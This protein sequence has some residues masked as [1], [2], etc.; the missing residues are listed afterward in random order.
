[1]DR[2]QVIAGGAEDVSGMMRGALSAMP[3]TKARPKSAGA[4]LWP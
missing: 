1:M 3:I 2:L 4:W